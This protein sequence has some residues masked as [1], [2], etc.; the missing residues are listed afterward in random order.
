[1]RRQPITFVDES[2]GWLRHDARLPAPPL[3]I[4]IR[5][6]TCPASHKTNQTSPSTS[7]LLPTP[8]SAHQ[9]RIEI[10]HL[11]QPV[12][13]LVHLLVV[14]P[15]FLKVGVGEVD[16]HTAA[17]RRLGGALEH[18]GDLIRG[19]LG[20]GHV[21]SSRTGQQCARYSQTGLEVLSIG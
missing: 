7:D 20:R 12:V 15:G 13:D 2:G 21:L 5:E 4:N 19:R 18:R 8:K 14:H 6:C 1:M 11:H 10:L 9:S 17:H 16:Q 3:P